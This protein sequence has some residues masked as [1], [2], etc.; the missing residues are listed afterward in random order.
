VRH[1]HIRLERAR[2]AGRGSIEDRR[3]AP[4]WNHLS[5]TAK[6]GAPSEFEEIEETISPIALDKIA[7]WILKQ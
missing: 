5:Q 2:P 6:T 1:C 7:A 4:G 3:A